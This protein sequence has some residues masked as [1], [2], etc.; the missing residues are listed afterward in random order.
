MAACITNDEPDAV[1]VVM[2]MT[3]FSQR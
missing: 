2:S 1:A 3:I